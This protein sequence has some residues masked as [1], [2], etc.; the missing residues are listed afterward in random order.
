MANVHTGG[1]IPL[2]RMRGERDS[3]CILCS[4]SGSGDVIPGNLPLDSRDSRSIAHLQASGGFFRCP[5]RVVRGNSDT[6]PA[7]LESVPGLAEIL[8]LLQRG[9]DSTALHHLLSEIACCGR[10]V[11]RDTGYT[12]LF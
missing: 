1:T 2:V 9:I 12:A 10:R 11:A 7:L 4:W 3:R 5:K 6:R 8:V